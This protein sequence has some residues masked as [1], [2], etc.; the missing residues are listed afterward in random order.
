MPQRAPLLLFALAA[1]ACGRE[2]AAPPPTP[3]PPPASTEPLRLRAGLTL[4]LVPNLPGVPSDDVPEAS[5]RDVE[6]LA[7]DGR[8]LRLR[9]T[10]TVR[11]ETSESARRR[12]EWVRAASNAPTGATPL[13]TV[14]AVYE[15]HEIAGTL[16][17]PDPVTASAFLLPGLWPEGNATFAGASGLALPKGAFTDLKLRS[18]AR[19]P[20]FLVG[21]RLRQPASLLLTRAAELAGETHADGP[22]IWRRAAP[23]Q[24]F[25]L[26]VDGRPVEVASIIATNWFGTFEILDDAENPLVLAILPAPAP[27]R[28]LDLFA[29]AKVLKT[30]L[31]Y[32]VAEISSPPP[33]TV[34]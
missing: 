26:R 30:L 12:E 4:S 21:G 25:G 13:P 8:E 14:P 31:G 16:L 27:S 10:G 34:R 15:K 3:R 19:V 20:L 22:V 33:E 32:R 11:K 23:P 18:E 9:W 7:S 1:A 24:R 17:F 5:R 28:V 2:E 6:I 29:P